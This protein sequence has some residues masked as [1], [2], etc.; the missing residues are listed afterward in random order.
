[1]SIVIDELRQEHVEVLAQIARVGH[2]LEEAEVCRGFLDFLEHEVVS[3]FATEEEVL[4]PELARIP[5]I[6][7]GP[8]RVMNAEHDTFRDLLQAARRARH[9]GN[10]HK[11]SMIAIDLATLLQSHIA[12]EDGVLFPLALD[13]LTAEQ[14]DRVDSRDSKHAPAAKS[15][16]E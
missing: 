11:L 8:L 16:I 2:R 9:D 12:K 4:F 13:L 10:D 7:S 14:L 5:P 1:M 15:K 3:H 6:A